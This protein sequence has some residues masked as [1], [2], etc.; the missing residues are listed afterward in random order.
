MSNRANYVSATGKLEVQGLA[1]AGESVVGI[2]RLADFKRLETLLATNEG[3]LGFTVRGAMDDRGR[4][5]LTLRLEGSVTLTCQRCLLPYLHE[6]DSETEILLAATEEE[7]AVWDEGEDETVL[8]A[9]PLDLHEMLEDELLLALPYAPRHPEGVC[10][11]GGRAAASAQDQ[12]RP[13]ASLANLKRKQTGN[14][15]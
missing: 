9:A 10:A 3:S 8:A 14:E 1:R 2:V 7:L 6:L 5:V 4:P 12:T 13:F 15:N 11:P